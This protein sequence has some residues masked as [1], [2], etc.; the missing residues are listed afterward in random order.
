[1]SGVP[2]DV[3]ESFALAAAAGRQLRDALASVLIGQETVIDELLWCVLANGHA[4]LEGA[5][6][7]GK[8]LVVKSLSKCLGLSFSRIQCTPDLMP[9]D[10]TGGAI[11]WTSPASDGAQS[12]AFHFQRGPV[13]AQLLLVDEVNRASPKT[14]SA[15]LEAM[16]ERTVTALGESHPLPTPFLVVAT[17]NPIEL[18]GTY[19]LPEAQLDRFMLKI[20]VPNPGPDDLSKIL[21]R[22]TGIHTQAPEFVLSEG[23]LLEMMRC[24]R[25]LAV[26]T[27]VLQYVT[28]LIL[29]TNPQ[30]QNA[31]PLVRRTVRFGASVRGGQALL[32]GAKARA[33]LRGA[34]QVSFEDV[35]CV[36]PA[37]LRHRLIRTFAADAEGVTPDQVVA[38]ILEAVPFRT[39]QVRRAL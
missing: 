9:S 6:G 18:E 19:P 23:R 3:S 2:E 14:Q 8:T 12:P 36:A 29:A 26:S 13:F 31:I 33:L 1:M 21:A 11:L 35:K 24:C 7:V 38:A 25:E 37:A 28:D 39:E 15:L 20:L 5:P 16:Q 22:T 4:L 34:L 10:I 17:E 27:P 30:P 32:L